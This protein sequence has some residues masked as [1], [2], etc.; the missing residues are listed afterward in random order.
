MR[1]IYA[2]HN[3]QTSAATAYCLHITPRQYAINTSTANAT[4]G[5]ILKNKIAFV[6]GERI[7]GTME[8]AKAEE[9]QEIVLS[10]GTGSGSIV[11]TPTDDQHTISRVDILKPSNL[12]SSNIKDGVEIAGITGNFTHLTAGFA[13]VSD[14][15]SGKHFFVN[16]TQYQGQVLSLSDTTYYP[17]IDN[18]K[19]IINSRKF[20]IGNQRLPGLTFTNL[21][22][23]NIASGVIVKIGDTDRGDSSYLSVTGTAELKKPESFPNI[24]LNLAT[25]NQVVEPGDN[26]VYTGVT[27]LKPQDLDENNIVVG[28]EIAGV[29]GIFSSDGTAADTDIARNKV[30][31]VNGHRIVGTFD[32]FVPTGKITISNTAEINVANYA[33]AQVVDANLNASNIAAGVTILG[34]TG[35]YNNRKTEDICNISATSLD[36]ELHTSNVFTPATN[37]V[38][39]SVIVNKPAFLAAENIKQGVIIAGISG[40]YAGI[41]PSGTINITNTS[42]TNVSAFEYAQITDSNLDAGNIRA[43]FSVLGIS[44]TFTNDATA[45]SSD[46]LYNKTAYVNGNLVTGSYK[47]AN[48]INVLSNE[49]TF[50][51][52][53]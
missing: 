1:Q 25:G 38:F 34:I 6:D 5:E 17:D 18:A 33:T 7:V 47:V 14:V 48:N 30:A 41:V 37:H 32:G 11:V 53:D 22:A 10:F 31:Y 9:T 44:G 46:I 50:E 40:T 27:I 19:V 3:L 2:A 45:T 43:G 16:G 39:N 52:K 51:N 49:L 4:A 21:A 28:K 23:S 42:L 35:S 20:I 29:T 15:L 26:S 13:T 12:Q 8:G 36:F 24:V